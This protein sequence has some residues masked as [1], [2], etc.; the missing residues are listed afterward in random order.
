MD[1]SNIPTSDLVKEL[2]K[3]D[4]VTMFGRPLSEVL[5]LVQ[6]MDDEDYR[7]RYETMRRIEFYQSCG[8]VEPEC[9]RNESWHQPLEPFYEGGRVRLRCR[10]CNYVQDEIPKSIL[11]CITKFGDMESFKQNLRLQTDYC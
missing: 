10:D 6:R 7:M 5:D 1:I 11:M 9:C 2:S 4:N 3:R 8:Y